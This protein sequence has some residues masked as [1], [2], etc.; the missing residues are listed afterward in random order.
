MYY[1]QFL[2]QYDAIYKIYDWYD[3]SLN[4]QFSASHINW[5]GQPHCRQ[6]SGYDII[7]WIA[8]VVYGIGHV[9]NL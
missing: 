7:D 4:L 8:L 5:A 3:T 9:D 1:G 6:F 2:C